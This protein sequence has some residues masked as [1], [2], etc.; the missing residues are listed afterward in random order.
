MTVYRIPGD[1]SD[2]ARGTGFNPS[3]VVCWSVWGFYLDWTPPGSGDG[4]Q[5]I[6]FLET[7]RMLRVE[8]YSTPPGSG[9]EVT[10]NRIAPAIRPGDAIQAATGFIK[11]VNARLADQLGSHAAAELSGFAAGFC[12]DFAV[13][14]VGMQ[15]AFACAHSAQL[16]A[17]PVQHI[18]SLYTDREDP[19]RS[20]AHG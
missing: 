11:I 16:L 2:A 17:G 13:R 10:K 14:L 5:S 4:R 1:T 12:G 15:A 6:R 7:R 9:D 3:G 19:R 8:W 20:Q 18:E